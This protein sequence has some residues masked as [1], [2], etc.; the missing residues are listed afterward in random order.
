[1]DEVQRQLEKYISLQNN[2]CQVSFSNQI[3]TKKDLLNYQANKK[4]DN[5]KQNEFTIILH[6]CEGRI[7][8]TDN[9]GIYDSFIKYQICQNYGR[10]ILILTNVDQK[11]NEII[12]DELINQAGQ[13]S[14]QYFKQNNLIFVCKDQM[15]Q[16]AMELIIDIL[17]KQHSGSF[18]PLD[19]EQYFQIKNICHDLK[20]SEIKQILKM[21]QT[22]LQNK[23]FQFEDNINLS[24][25]GAQHLNQTLAQ[26]LNSTIKNPYMNDTH[27][28]F[29]NTSNNII[30]SNI[31]MQ[32]TSSLY[33]TQQQRDEMK[34][35]SLIQQQNTSQSREYESDSQQSDMIQKQKNKN[36]P[37]P[38]RLSNQ[39]DGKKGKK[40]RN[41]LSMRWRCNIVQRG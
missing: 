14:L 41:R 18:K 40:R 4:Y 9:N 31:L 27:L 23:T 34:F 28:A 6:K 16:K 19:L 33:M 38:F 26:N 32:Q 39:E 12:V 20:Q 2:L 10:V 30:N 1:M 25:I 11:Q 35:T 29:D 8:L 15:S 37:E 22:Q 13:K 17:V 36:K 21:Y 5:Q 3:L 24:K 7:L